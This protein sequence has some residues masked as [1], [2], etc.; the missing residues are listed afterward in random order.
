MEAKHGIAIV[1]VLSADVED[2]LAR[3]EIDTRHEDFRD[4]S[5]TGTG[6]HLVAIGNELLTIEVTMRIDKGKH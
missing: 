1:R 5:L 4:T 6:H 2:R 3:F